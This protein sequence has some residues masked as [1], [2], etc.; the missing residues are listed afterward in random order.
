MASCTRSCITYPVRTTVESTADDWTH[1]REHS[2]TEVYVTGTF[3]DWARSV[4][5]E[6]KGDHFE[7]LVELPLANENIYYKVRFS[8][9]P[10]QSI[11]RILWCQNTSIHEAGRGP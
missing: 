1:F 11:T 6:K 2:A 3:D 4:K 8:C 10:L 9:Q 5:L 7:K